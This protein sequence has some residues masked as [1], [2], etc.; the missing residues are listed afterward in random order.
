MSITQMTPNGPAENAGMRVNDIILRVDNV[1]TLA[2]IDV[3][4]ALNI[5]Q[6][7]QLVEIVVWRNRQEVALRVQMIRLQLAPDTHTP[8]KK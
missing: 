4:A 5:V 1:N 3:S 8:K 7:G 2:L 6:H